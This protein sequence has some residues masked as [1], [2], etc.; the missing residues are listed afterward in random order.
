MPSSH[1]VGYTSQP[2]STKSPPAFEFPKR[3]RWA[4]L[5]VSE[6]VDNIAFVISPTC[7]IWFCAAPVT[8][9]LG[10]RDTDL[11]DLD[12]LDLLD[13]SDH[14]RF[15]ESFNLAIQN[16]VEFDI[17]IK[18][19][20][21]ES[22][23]SFGAPIPVPGVVF[24]IK[25]RPYTV[26]DPELEVKCL[27]AMA[28]PYPGRNT[29]ILDTIIDLKAKQERLQRRLAELQARVP[30]E[31]SPSPGSTSQNS[32]YATSSLNAKKPVT[33]SSGQLKSSDLSGSYLSSGSL[34]GKTIED[35]LRS[36]LDPTEFGTEDPIEEGS[37]KKKQKR[38]Q[39]AEQYVC[40][41]CGR[42]E[43]PEWRKGPLG[44]KT[45]CNAC[46]LR[47][48]KQMRKDPADAGGSSNVDT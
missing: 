39:T 41:T 10:W 35:P 13:E 44:P 5:L 8:E 7:K 25:C 17:S 20:K 11:I 48:A 21:C 14:A 46:G 40:V 26:A 43:S 34:A 32:M 18:L 2:L 22:P 12:F 1:S 38:A 24:S 33:G 45:L 9:L 47:W 30:P 27:I 29:A 31:A 28:T 3:K 16:G 36:L 42:T 4:D 19:K 6:L 15:Q 23:I 37:K